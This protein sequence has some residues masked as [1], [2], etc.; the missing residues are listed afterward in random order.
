MYCGSVDTDYNAGPYT[1]VFTAGE[2]R[3]SFSVTIHSDDL[4]EGN[5]NFTLSINASL[6]PSNVIV[7]DPH[8]TTVTIVDNDCEFVYCLL[9]LQWSLSIP[10][11]LKSCPYYIGFLNSAHMESFWYQIIFS[12]L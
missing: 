9:E 10:D 3:T 6:L 5:E 11:T 1:A 4:V 2:T 12:L 7:R 8:Q